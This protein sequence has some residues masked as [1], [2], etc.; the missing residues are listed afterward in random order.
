MCIDDGRLHA[1]EGTG[2]TV[3]SKGGA[4]KQ[5]RAQRE[6][7]VVCA[8]ACVDRLEAIVFAVRRW[9]LVRRVFKLWTKDSVFRSLVRM[10]YS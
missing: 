8:C 1:F 2:W 5:V 4:M 6:V 9:R 10:Y 3:S 7:T